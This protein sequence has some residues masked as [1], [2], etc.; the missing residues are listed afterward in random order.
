MTDI[1]MLDI[2]N[3]SSG[4]KQPQAIGKYIN[5]ELD[6]TALAGPFGNDPFEWL[7]YNPMMCREKKE[8][9]TYRVILDLSY[10]D[11]NAVELNDLQN[12]I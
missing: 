10:P 3:H 1:P 5:N 11:G 9:G 8:V 7:R 12:V 2:D 6:F 4:R